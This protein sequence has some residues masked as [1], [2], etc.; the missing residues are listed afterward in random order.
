MKMG[1]FERKNGR[2]PD[3]Q[4]GRPLTVMAVDNDRI[5]VCIENKDGSTLEAF[6][7]A[8]QIWADRKGELFLALECLKFGNL[9]A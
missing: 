4:K 5:H 8:D 7:D 6:V 9:T 3:G 1:L 2:Y